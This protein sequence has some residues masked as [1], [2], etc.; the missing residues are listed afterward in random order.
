MLNRVFF[1]C[2]DRITHVRRAKN[3]C[4]VGDPFLSVSLS[5]SLS[6]LLHLYFCT[7][8]SL[9]H[10]VIFGAGHSSHT[11]T[12]VAQGQSKFAA[13]L[14]CPRMETGIRTNTGTTP[15][16]WS[17]AVSAPPPPTGRRDTEKVVQESGHK[18]KR[19]CARQSGAREKGPA[20]P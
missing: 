13:K 3:L 12:A 17:T 11:S 4:V 9:P 14:S 8:V 6:F 16:F 18:K 19:I 10:T 1:W 15:H 7:V 20:T 2:H 5:L